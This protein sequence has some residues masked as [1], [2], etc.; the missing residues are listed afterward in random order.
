MV[1]EIVSP[2][3]TVCKL[4]RNDTKINVMAYRHE[5][6]AKGLPTHAV[7][8]RFLSWKEDQ[9]AKYWISVFS[10]F[11]GLFLHRV[12]PQYLAMLSVFILNVI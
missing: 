3:S 9:N 12:L 6:H 2:K 4:S 1:C 10:L 8:Y 7:L 11:P 5:N